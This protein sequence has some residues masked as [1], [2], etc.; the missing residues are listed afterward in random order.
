MLF[1]VSCIIRVFEVKRILMWLSVDHRATSIST[2]YMQI[3]VYLPML[4]LKRAILENRWRY[5]RPVDIVH[6]FLSA[7]M[8]INAMLYHIQGSILLSCLLRKCIQLTKI[9]GCLAAKSHSTRRTLY[10]AFAEGLIW[11]VCWWWGAFSL[12]RLCNEFTFSDLLS[13][14]TVTYK[15]VCDRWRFIWI[16]QKCRKLCM[17]TP[18]NFRGGGLTAG[19]F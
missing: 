10:S 6:K 3:Y 9:T 18:P 1:I 4:R 17:P 12:T 8:S 11:P 19:S 13:S 5:F 16:G 15:W 7:Y 2:K 14:R